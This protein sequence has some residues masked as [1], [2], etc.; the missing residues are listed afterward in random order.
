[1]DAYTLRTK[2]WLEKRYKQIDKDGIYYA[3]Q[4]IYGF[5]K[6]HSE[7]GL[8]SKYIRTYWIMKALS[9]LN[10]DSLLDI[11]AA[12]GYKAW[13]VKQIFNI[14]VVN[15]DLSE[16]ACK[17]S[18][19]IFGIEAIS[20]DICNLPFKDNEYDVVLCSETLEHV[21]DVSKAFS[22]LLRVARKAV[23]ITVP[24]ESREFIEQNINKDVIHGHIHIFNLDSFNHL[25][26]KG[27]MVFSERMISPL[28]NVPYVLTESMH[29]EYK[30]E[31]RYPKIFTDLYNILIPIIRLVIGKRIGCFLVRIDDYICKHSSKYEAIGYLVV[32]DK[33][34]F[35][36]REAKD[37]SINRIIDFTVPFYH[38]HQ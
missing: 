8:F 7:P 32:K 35:S 36:T 37:I 6:Y 38:L 21:S 3:H 29:R 2:K 16:E 11:G 27:Y 5:H 9:H 23:I 17:R 25:L 18:K 4:P 26:S 13:I 22:E 34:C 28:L 33:K 14:K 31:S 1:M 20:A 19:E 15:S 30:K 12:E 24:H 10:V